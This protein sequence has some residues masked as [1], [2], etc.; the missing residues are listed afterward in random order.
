M[1]VA[2]SAPQAEQWLGSA[3]RL[4]VLGIV[5]ARGLG[6]GGALDDALL[7]LSPVLWAV[8]LPEVLSAHAGLRAAVER[9]LQWPG[10]SLRGWIAVATLG[11]V[12]LPG[13]AWAVRPG[14]V[15]D[16]SAR[17]APMA[18]WPAPPPDIDVRYDFM[19]QLREVRDVRTGQA[20]AGFRWRLDPWRGI[21]LWPFPTDAA[22][23]SFR[24]GVPPVP[25]QPE[26]VYLPLV[27]DASAMVTDPFAPQPWHRLHLVR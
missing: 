18:N 11:L 15:A 21:V 9:A 1:T 4:A 7:L 14:A 24:R 16:L 10:R 6:G 27:P 22:M 20:P 13:S 17:D 8:L 3:A 12:V 26:Y 5:T 25:A 19:G 23:E 2:D